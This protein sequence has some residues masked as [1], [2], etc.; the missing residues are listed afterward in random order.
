MYEFPTIETT[1]QYVLHH[2]LML[3]FAPKIDEDPFAN[4]IYHQA[5]D[6]IEHY[7]LK[8][9]IVKLNA[10]IIDFNERKIALM[11]DDDYES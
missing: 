4:Y 2:S 6:S 3:Y 8:E 5:K 7:H 1:G 9:K 11:N 10:D